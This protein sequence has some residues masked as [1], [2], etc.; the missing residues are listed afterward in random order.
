[1][2]NFHPHPTAVLVTAVFSNIPNVLVTKNK[3]IH[4]LGTQCKKTQIVALI[5][6]I[7]IITLLS[8]G[9]TTV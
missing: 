4:A 2:R 5:I 6:L 7:I 1:M 3:T 9:Q 8:A